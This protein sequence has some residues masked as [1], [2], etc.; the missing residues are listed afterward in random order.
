ML[1]GYWPKTKA[2]YPPFAWHLYSVN[3]ILDIVENMPDNEDP[4]KG[5]ENIDDE[6]EKEAYPLSEGSKPLEIEGRQLSKIILVPHGAPEMKTDSELA[7]LLMKKEN[8]LEKVNKAFEK[9]KAELEELKKTN[10]ELEQSVKENG[11]KEKASLSEE[12]N[13]LREKVGLEKIEKP[14]ELSL[15]AINAKLEDARALVKKL[16]DKPG[17]PD[18]KLKKELSDDDK[19]AAKKKKRMEMLGKE[20]AAGDEPKE[21]DN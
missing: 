5:D 11:D 17:P 8:E 7:V 16:E 4:P 18:P 20:Y 2:A 12:L 1:Q 15:D 9:M 13:T 3:E 19:A 14:E 10:G 21:G 6:V